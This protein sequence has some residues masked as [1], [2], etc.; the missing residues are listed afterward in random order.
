MAKE[1][2]VA[3]AETLIDLAKNNDKILVLEADLMN[4]TGTKI[5]KKEFPE[6]MIDVGVAEANMVGMAAGLAVNGY[7]PFAATFGTFASRRAFDQF[8]ISGAYAKTNV[9]L[10]GTDPGVTAAFN[11][12]THMPFED[13]GMMRL[14]PNLVI[15]EPSDPISA[16]AF[17]RLIAEYNGCCYMRLHRK[18]MD[19]IYNSN[20][21]FEI[22]KSKIL[23]DGD[24]VCIFALGAVLVHEA[25]KAS[26]HLKEEGINVRV[27]DVLTLKPIDK[28]CILKC[29]KECTNI[30]TL[31]NNQ[32]KCGLYSTVLEVFNENRVQ[33]HVTSIGAH[34]EFGQVGTLDYLLK[35]YGMDENSIMETVRNL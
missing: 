15:V 4:A 34:D 30:I 10:I 25:L 29:A 9:K 13:T 27:V 35:A 5:F 12:G 33:K 31:E 18:G 2:R 3:Y 24:D 1:M 23:R 17:T 11:G 21:K 20:E 32:V 22:G 8:F 6:R 7:I 19:D 28:D 14:V 16:S 26:D